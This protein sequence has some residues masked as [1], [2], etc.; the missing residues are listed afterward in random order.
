M[1]LIHSNMH[2]QILLNLFQQLFH[3][4]FNLLISAG[5]H[6]IRFV[7]HTNIWFKLVV[8]IDYHRN[9]DFNFA[10]SAAKSTGFVKKSSA[11]SCM[12]CL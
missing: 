11:P 5:S 4:F 6:F 2:L 1:E 7:H 3:G 8:F 10:F 9:L 12:A